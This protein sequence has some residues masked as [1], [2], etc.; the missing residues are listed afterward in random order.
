MM[1]ITLIALTFCN[2]YIQYVKLSKKETFNLIKTTLCTVNLQYVIVLKN[3]KYCYHFFN[4][5]L[6]LS[7]VCNSS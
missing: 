7:L 2:V 4:I 1:K 6:G 5:L 3:D